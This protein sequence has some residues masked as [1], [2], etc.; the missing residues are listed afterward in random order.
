MFYRIR[1]I[2]E[3]GIKFIQYDVPAKNRAQ[4]IRIAVRRHNKAYARAEKDFRSK[5]ATILSSA[6][7]QA[8]IHNGSSELGW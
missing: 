4:A 8:Y 5:I 7:R 3:N 2:A 6:K 1:I